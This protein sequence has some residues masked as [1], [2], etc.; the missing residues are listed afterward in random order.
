VAFRVLA[1]FV[2]AAVVW[3]ALFLY[4]KRRGVELEQRHAKHHGWEKETLAVRQEVWKCPHCRVPLMTWYDVLAHQSDTS[5]CGRLEVTRT[6]EAAAEAAKEAM[7]AA[8]AAGRWSVS[9][10]TG[11]EEHSGAVDTFVKGELESGARDDA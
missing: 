7:K 2:L 10:T 3:Y 8:E 6:A 5:P 11:G 1:L 9:A 4:H